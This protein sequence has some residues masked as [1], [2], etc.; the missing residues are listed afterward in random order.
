MHLLISWV[1][2]VVYF[3]IGAVRYGLFLAH[4]MLPVGYQF[5][6]SIKEL[7]VLNDQILVGFSLES[8]Q[9]F[10]INL[11]HVID[12]VEMASARHS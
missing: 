9:H 1:R 3:E 6:L 4:Y 7:Q 12:K 10:L 11:T 2:E 5:A 8:I